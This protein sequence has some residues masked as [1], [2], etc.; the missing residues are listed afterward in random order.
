MGWGPVIAYESGV[1]QAKGQG[2]LHNTA[3][4]YADNTM[5]IVDLRPGGNSIYGET[6]WYWYGYNI[7]CGG[8][9]WYFDGQSQTGRT[10]DGFWHSVTYGASSRLMLRSYAGNQKCARIKHGSPIHVQCRRF[11][12]LAIRQSS[13]AL[14]RPKT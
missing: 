1:G 8:V 5:N 9:C 4:V 6:G 3:Y 2:D 12:T 10:S 14:I 13:L 7:S 11:R